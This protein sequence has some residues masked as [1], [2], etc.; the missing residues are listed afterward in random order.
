VHDP[1]IYK[2]ALIATSA[3]TATN[4]YILARQL[5]G[6]ANFMATLVG[7]TTLFALVTIPFVFLI[8]DKLT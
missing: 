6:D 5:G 7:T 1:D 2:V 3:P 8:F 4:S